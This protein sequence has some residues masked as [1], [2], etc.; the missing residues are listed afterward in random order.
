MK[1]MLN[2]TAAIMGLLVGILLSITVFAQSDGVVSGTLHKTESGK[3]PFY[4]DDNGQEQWT[5][6]LQ[7][8]YDEKMGATLKELCSDQA[9]LGELEKQYIAA[10][11][12]DGNALNSHPEVGTKIE[13]LK[14]EMVRLSNIV[15]KG[16]GQSAR[17]W[18]CQ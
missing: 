18:G 4:F 9:S 14:A 5:D 7:K 12:N 11:H 8:S 13:A 6:A 17:V 3:Y 1:T 2:V 15:L 10:D 16:T